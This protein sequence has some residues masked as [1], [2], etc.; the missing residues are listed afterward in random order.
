MLAPRELLVMEKCP[1][2]SQGVPSQDWQGGQCGSYSQ[3]KE[4]ERT[5]AGDTR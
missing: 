4:K 2:G 1:L 5:R 3:G